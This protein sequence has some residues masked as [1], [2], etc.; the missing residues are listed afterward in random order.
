M[1]DKILNK[2]LQIEKERF[3]L[4]NRLE[5]VSTETLNLKPQPDKWSIIQIVHHLY[6]SEQLS[7][8]YI[9]R[10][11]R[12]KTKIKKSSI[13]SFVRG[14]MLEWALRFPTKLKAPSNVADVPD[15]AELEVY[16]KKWEKIRS[17]LKEIIVNTE[18]EILLNDVFF[19]PAVGEMNMINA[20]KFMD[21]HFHHH[22]KQIDKILL[23]NNKLV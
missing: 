13:A 1:S 11:L 5:K 10:K 4:F 3:E 7:I 16:E 9:K 14:L 17:D 8:V 22:K 15:F 12:D 23:F 2:F 18:E 6:K 19:H 20:L 21:A